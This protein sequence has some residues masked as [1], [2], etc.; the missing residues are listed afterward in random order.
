M[1]RMSI[2]DYMTRFKSFPFSDMRNKKILHI[3]ND[4]YFILEIHSN[5][6]FGT[7]VLKKVVMKTCTI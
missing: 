4:D 5:S 1:L 3:N 6:E 7:V 2:W